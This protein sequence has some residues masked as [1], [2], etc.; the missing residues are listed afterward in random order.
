MNVAFLFNSDHPLLGGFYGSPIMERILGTQVLQRTSRHMRVSIGD[1]LT[2][3]SVSTSEE[4]ENLCRGVY[5]PFSLDLLLKERLEKTY[6]TATVYCWLFQN[7]TIEIV[8]KLHEKLISCDYYLGS[9]DV[10]FSLPIHLIFFRN[11]LCEMYRI[12]SNKCWI[13]YSMG[14]N[15][16]PDISV[17]EMFIKYGF[18]IDYED[19]GA[20][21]TIFD[22]Y[23]YL[24]H[25]QR[26]KKFCDIFSSFTKVDGDMLSDIIINLEEIHPNLFDSFSS[27]AMAIQRAETEEDIA[28]ASLSGR[29]VLEKIADYLFPPQTDD[30]NG[31]K[32]GEAEYKNRLWAY[33]ENTLLGI[34]I[35]DKNVLER[36]GNEVNRLIDL[37]NK[38]IHSKMKKIEIEDAFCDLI[39]WLLEIV[40]ISPSAIRRPY[41]A[42]QKKL[43]EFIA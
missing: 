13:F 8:E 3:S 33:I 38:G 32:I 31:R 7:I 27:A 5:V 43:L 1:I 42:Y 14:E 2:Y 26:I 28:Q 10:N 12:N 37:F 20:R 30:W 25:F 9:M 21:R 35:Q 19:I 16:D 39:I 15:E 36:M 11:Y 22:D 40:N 18:Y 4:L 6:S 17:K 24:E 41:V 34:G 23:D 29:R